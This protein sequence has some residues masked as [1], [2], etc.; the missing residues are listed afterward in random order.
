M[1]REAR[2]VLVAGQHCQVVAQAKLRKER[3]DRPDPHPGAAALVPQVRGG[4][5]IRAVGSQQRYRRKS[6]NDRAR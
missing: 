5:M 2:E 4:D 6:F 1:G 3:V